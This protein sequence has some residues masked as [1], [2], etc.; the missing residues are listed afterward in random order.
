MHHD[1]GS[2][3]TTRLRRALGLASVRTLINLVGLERQTT[4]AMHA[5]E[6][7]RAVLCISLFP[8]CGGI[9]HIDA[10]LDDGLVSRRYDLSLRTIVP[11]LRF[12]VDNPHVVLHMARF[13]GRLSIQ[14]YSC[15]IVTQL[16]AVLRESG[17]RVPL[18]RLRVKRY[19]ALA[20]AQHD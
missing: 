15:N 20:L 19:N 9:G 8:M 10:S 14:R 3:L 13:R 2:L 12:I 16:S 1:A 6:A 17:H 4:D 5:P 11:H 18:D 7:K